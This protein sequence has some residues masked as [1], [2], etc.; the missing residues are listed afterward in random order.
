MNVESLY[1]R[2]CVAGSGFPGFF[3]S[4]RQPVGSGAMLRVLV[5]PSSFSD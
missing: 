1:G 4:L 3:R 2:G 5:L